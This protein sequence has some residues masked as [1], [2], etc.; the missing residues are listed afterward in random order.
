MAIPRHA[1]DEKNSLQGTSH[2]L[3]E[4]QEDFIARCASCHGPDGSGSTQIGRGLYP[5]VPNLRLTETQNPT[6]GEIHYIQ[7]GVQFTGMATWRK[8]H[9]EEDGDGRKLVLS[10]R[11]FVR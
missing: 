11:N 9:Q 8:P 6:D 10:I 4:G 7:N 1:H 2:E 3:Q 5:R